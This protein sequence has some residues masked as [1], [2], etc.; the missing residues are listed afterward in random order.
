MEGKVIGGIGCSGATWEDGVVA[1]A[2]LMALG[3]DTPEAEACL[4]DV[5]VPPEKW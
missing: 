5:G 4:T 1:W 3:A 2:G